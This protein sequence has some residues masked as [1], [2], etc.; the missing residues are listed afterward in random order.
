MAS[1]RVEM[2]LN[3]KVRELRV[4][5]GGTYEL[6]VDQILRPPLNLDHP[7]IFYCAEEA[8]PVPDNYPTLLTPMTIHARAVFFAVP[9][10]ALQQIHL[11]SLL[12]QSSRFQRMF[13]SIL[14]VPLMR[15]YVQF[16]YKWFPWDAQT[17]I[18]SSGPIRQFFPVGVHLG[19]FQVY[20][21]DGAADYWD[22]ADTRGLTGSWNCYTRISRSS[23]HSTRC[24]PR[25]PSAS[26]APTTAPMPP[27]CFYRGSPWT[28]WWTRWFNRGR[29]RRGDSEIVCLFAAR[30]G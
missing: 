5:D 16:P 24:P 17:F 9:Q 25:T 30:R 11:P 6:A 20:M 29:G 4:L 23:F 18:I 13:E 1:G 19:I 3:Q 15:V 27:T 7:P 10:A 21:D 2:R 26:S 12:S 22:R 8:R 14:P 28:R